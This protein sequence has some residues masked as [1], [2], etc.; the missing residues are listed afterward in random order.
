M[1]NARL[2]YRRGSVGEYDNECLWVE[3]TTDQNDPDTGLP[4]PLWGFAIV[5]HD[6]RVWD[7]GMALEIQADSWPAFATHGSLF[8]ILGKASGPEWNRETLVMAL[9][10]Y[11][12]VSYFEEER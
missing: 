7:L 3:M 6:S 8:A 10:E 4:I 11:G 5:P 2:T 1:T 12:A 9:R